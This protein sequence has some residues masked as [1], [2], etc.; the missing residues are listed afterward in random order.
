MKPPEFAGFGLGQLH[1][2]TE[3]QGLSFEAKVALVTASVAVA[4]LI[5]AG[6][7]VA[8]KCPQANQWLKGHVF[9]PMNT[10]QI[11]VKQ[12][13]LY[14]SAPLAGVGLLTVPLI[15][16]KKGR[17]TKDRARTPTLDRGELSDRQKLGLKLAAVAV[18]LA[19][20]GVGFY[21]LQ[22][23]NQTLHTALER[24]LSLTD[25]LKYIA[26]PTAGALAIPNLALCSLEKKRP[27]GYNT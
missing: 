4:I 21:F 13:L 7:F 16:K 25:G 12:G 8:I 2:S 22:A 17:F 19:A 15:L 26:T 10:T 20:L 11:S 14:M 27:L 18:A 9:T 23:H 3:Q 6:I 24:R 5:G 1:I